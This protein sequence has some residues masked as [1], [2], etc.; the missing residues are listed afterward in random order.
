[1][2]ELQVSIVL[3]LGLAMANFFLHSQVLQRRRIATNFAYGASAADIAVI[4]LVLIVGGGFD[5][6]PYVFYFLALSVAFPTRVTMAFTVATVAVYGLVSLATAAES[7][8]PTVVTQMLM[9]AA[10]AFCGNTYWRI[11]RDRRQAAAE[12]RETLEA[13]VEEEKVQTV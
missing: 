5:T 12:T 4:S 1:M 8:A 2:G 6:I 9:M 13:R 10:V 3:I 7:Q 11:E